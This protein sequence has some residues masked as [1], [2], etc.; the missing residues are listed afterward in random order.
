MSYGYI[1]AYLAYGFE[2]RV[3]DPKDLEKNFDCTKASLYTCIED[4][5]ETIGI[6]KQSEGKRKRKRKRTHHTKY[7]CFGI[8]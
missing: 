4:E 2:V 7:G 6:E 3:I 1:G 8:F 5:G